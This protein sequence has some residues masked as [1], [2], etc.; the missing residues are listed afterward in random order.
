MQVNEKVS[1]SI[2][3]SEALINEGSTPEL[4]WNW[5]FWAVIIA[6]VIILF[7]VAVLLRGVGLQ[8]EVLHDELYN[9]LAARGMLEHGD[10]LITPAGQTYDRAALFTRMVAA[11]MEMFGQSLLVARI[12]ALLAGSLIVVIVFLWLRLQ[13]QRA[14]GW[15]AGLLI[16]ADPL[17]IQLSQVV[18]FYSFQHLVFVIGGIGVYLLL[19]YRAGI[20]FKAV[21]VCLTTAA[22]FL[23]L[24]MQPVSAFGLGG[25]LIFIAVVLFF[26]RIRTLNRSRQLQ[27]VLAALVVT[28]IGLLLSYQSGLMQHY[29][30]LM[31]YADLWAAAAVDNQ[32][33]YYA[34][35]HSNYAPLWAFF[36]L[37]LV[38]AAVRRPAITTLCATI[39]IVGF[40][41]L[42]MASWKAERYFA[43]LMPFFFIVVS[44]GLVQGAVFLYRYIH[45]LAGKITPMHQRYH[46]LLSILLSVMILGVAMLGNYGFLTTS[47]LLLRD[48]SFS[49]PLMGQND[50]SLSWSRAASKLEDVVNEVD[51]LVSSDDL[52]ALYYLG[53]VDY[54][55]SPNSLHKLGGRL[56]EFTPDRYSR[57]RIFESTEAMETIMKCHKSGLFI[58]Q[59]MSLNRSP[60]GLSR[61]QATRLVK[62][63]AEQI[64]L[65][66]KW[67]LLAFRWHTPEEKIMENCP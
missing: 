2:H 29:I 48:H 37:W 62:E 49:F 35:L 42:S 65:P 13:G 8:E 55:L 31:S 15:L 5:R 40:T 3:T 66:Q 14:A 24:L 41:G 51:V 58:V 43:Y 45:V 30:N 54:V 28:C 44:L 9:F 36:P 34:F 19:F 20:K 56:K 33:Y 46:G 59:S 21:L 12:P 25:V 50:G 32:R 23:A 16:A 11:F 1:G 22:L 64:A 57:A 10:L 27:I 17:L 7:I 52:K 63:K 26:D 47:R 61:M 4:V 60:Q 18:R 53:R 67:G 38:F 6:E 39:F